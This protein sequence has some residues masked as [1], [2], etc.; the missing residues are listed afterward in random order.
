MLTKYT[1]LRVGHFSD[2]GSAIYAL[3]IV[4]LKI[5][6]SQKFAYILVLEVSSRPGPDV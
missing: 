6:E 3:Y 1:S 4:A 2:T 5:A